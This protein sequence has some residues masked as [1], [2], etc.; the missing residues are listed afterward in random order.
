MST[1]AV[2][3]MVRIHLLTGW[4]ALGSWVLATGLTMLAVTRSVG[5]LY[6]TP[7][8]IHSYAVAVGNG[9]ALVAINGRVAGIDSLGG[10]VANEAGFLASFAIPLMGVSLVARMTRRDEE[11]GRLEAL[12]AGRVGR[13]APLVAALLVV[14]GALVAA[15]AALFVALV[16]VGVPAAASALYAASMG[17]LGLVFA[18]IAALTAQVVEH[19]RGVYAVGLAAILL[20]YLLRGVGD[21]LQNAVT[22]L[23]PLGWQENSRAFGDQRW[24]PLLVPVLVAAALA[25]LAVVECSRRDLG[26]AR[27]RRAGG[28][29]SASRLLR[30]PLGTVLRLR[31][32][33]ILG[34]TTGT[35]VVAAAFGTLAQPLLEAIEGNPAVAKALGA[36][37]ATG[38]DTVLS[39]SVLILALL[40][41]GYVV[42][43]VAM[44]RAEE[45]SHRLETRLAGTDGRAFWLGLQ[46]L[47]L[48]AGLV[49]I[50]GLGAL[51]LAGGTVV[52]TGQAVAGT[53][54][55]ATAAFLPAIALLGALA[56]ALFGL[57]P[58]AQPVAWLL[59]AVAALIAYLGD[60]L[61]LAAPVLA[62]SPYHAVGNPP[63]D[64]V[65]A[66]AL[67]LLG[68]L[69]VGL[70]LLG[71]VGF[72]RRDVP[73]D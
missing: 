38:L 7:A 70:G 61:R 19:S 29:T 33:S 73:R 46:V 65:R 37:G 71:L 51:A 26:S 53:V 62:L 2:P 14:T 11:D 31:G 63:Q 64:P 56:L 68:A 34:W 35:V 15:A 42:Q 10:I 49:P 36:S 66:G 41:G 9:G 48:V 59:F 69:A 4:K 32:G 43:G 6:D 54:L 40:A 58:R 23:S 30:S 27:L 20:A 13:S 5:G 67:A 60:P 52:S 45:T 55:R 24:W 50:L 16:L 44:L 28:P 47:V 21:V 8:K 3:T 22:W 57:L 25:G 18:G 1:L 12:L 17:A 39:M 72:R